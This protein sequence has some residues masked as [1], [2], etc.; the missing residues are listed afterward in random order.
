MPHQRTTGAWCVCG[1]AGMLLKRYRLHELG[2]SVQCR[3]VWKCGV[4]Q[5][6]DGAT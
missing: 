1:E 2:I 6:F 3:E 5:I 4:S